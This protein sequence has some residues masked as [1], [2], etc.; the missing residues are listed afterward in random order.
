MLTIMLSRVC[1]LLCVCSRERR[2]EEKVE[3]IKA[4]IVDLE[5][6]KRSK[7]EELKR[8]SVDDSGKSVEE[9]LVAE[10][11]KHEEAKEVYDDWL[12]RN[13]RVALNQRL[14][15]ES[16]K[17]KHESDIMQKRFLAGEIPH[18]RFIMDFREL[19]RKYHELMIKLEFEKGRMSGSAP[20]ASAT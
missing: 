11:Q 17:L 12:S 7:Q 16:L 18:E 13:S 6:K 10:K 20:R 15:A 19:R 3:S 4:Q 2:I 1:V 14:E 5:A 8:L 9:L